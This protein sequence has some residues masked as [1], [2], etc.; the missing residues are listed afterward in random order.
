MDYFLHRMSA[1]RLPFAILY[2]ERSDNDND[3]YSN[4]KSFVNYLPEG[5]SNDLA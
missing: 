2:S 4:C 1:N 3:E 5:K